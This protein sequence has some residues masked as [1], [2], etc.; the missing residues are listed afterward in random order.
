VFG[1]TTINVANKAL[2]VEPNNLNKQLVTYDDAFE[3]ILEKQKVGLEVRNETN[4]R[5][6]DSKKISTEKELINQE[7]DDESLK[8]KS[9]EMLEILNSISQLIMQMKSELGDI[10]ELGLEDLNLKLSGLKQVL[11]DESSIGLNKG[12]L[13][14]ELN[15]ISQFIESITDVINK[16][17]LAL[18]EEALESNLKQIISQFKSL[19]DSIK[20]NSNFYKEI[21]YASIL[22]SYNMLQ[23]EESNI[24]VPNSVQLTNLKNGIFDISYDLKEQKALAEKMNITDEISIENPKDTD[25]NFENIDVILHNYLIERDSIDGSLQEVN[26]YNDVNQIYKEDIVKQIVDKMKLTLDDYKQ[27]LEIKLKPDLLGKLI[28]KM[29]LKDGIVN[30]KLLVD[31]YRT[32]ELIESNIA[33]LKEQ[34][35]EIGVDIKTFEV[36]VGANHDFEGHQKE[37]LN[38]NLKSNKKMRVKDDLLEGV[39]AY[40]ESLTGTSLV[41]YHEGQLNLF[42]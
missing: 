33:Q 20:D 3:H 16:I 15:D 30:A 21:N 24:D 7:K 38:Y 27:E 9:R 12:L 6:G 35:K 1:I 13:S 17:D 2:D 4:V 22:G 34:I 23:E 36:Y 8:N 10:P 42:A 32:K 26:N 39:Q 41:N 19:T 40:D 28:L 5:A 14:S 29:E 25:S 11:F 18:D 37:K 31:N